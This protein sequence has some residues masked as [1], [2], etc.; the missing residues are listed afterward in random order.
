VRLT[1]K[2]YLALDALARD[3]DCSRT[4][5]DPEEEFV[6]DTMEQ[7]WYKLTS[8]ERSYLNNEHVFEYRCY[9]GGITRHVELCCECARGNSDG[10][11]QNRNPH[12][13]HCDVARRMAP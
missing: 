5:E 10:C 7:L 4:D 13:V 9:C 8:E 12:L 2:T 3:F 6:R 1:L 11:C